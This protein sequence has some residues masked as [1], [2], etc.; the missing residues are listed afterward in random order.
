[1]ELSCEFRASVALPPMKQSEL[2][3]EEEIWWS[4]HLYCVCWR[5]VL[6]LHIFER[7]I[8]Q[9]VGLSLGVARV[10]SEQKVPRSVEQ[11]IVIKFLVEKT[12]R[13]LKFTTDSNNSM[14]KGVSSK[15]CKLVNV[16][17]LLRSYKDIKRSYSDFSYTAY[18]IRVYEY[19][20][21][22]SSVKQTLFSLKLSEH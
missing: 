7:R 11:R 21:S 4:S 5:R 9:P 13:P 6:P 18:H 17:E 1:M 22:L 15:L 14:G 8:V 12:S 16:V 20:C 10:M 3:A 2:P 19:V